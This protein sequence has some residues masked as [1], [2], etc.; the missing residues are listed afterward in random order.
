MDP[1]REYI[2][3]WNEVKMEMELDRQDGNWARLQLHLGELMD[4][5]QAAHRWV[6]NQ[7]R[8]E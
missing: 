3:Y 1:V 8:E 2:D 4:K 7:P 6:Q 5:L